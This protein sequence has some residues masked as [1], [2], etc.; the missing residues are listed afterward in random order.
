MPLASTA[1]HVQSFIPPGPCLQVLYIPTAEMLTTNSSY[2]QAEDGSWLTHDAA[3]Q[4]ISSLVSNHSDIMSKLK[5]KTGTSAT[6]CLAT[7]HASGRGQPAIV[8]SQYV[9]SISP[10]HCVDLAGFS[11]QMHC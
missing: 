8:A 5:V 6:G 1:G 7:C 10:W 11:P 2:Q 9:L 4:V 3:R